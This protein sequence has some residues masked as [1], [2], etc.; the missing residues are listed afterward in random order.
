VED[1]EK[2]VIYVYQDLLNEYCKYYEP[3]I[4]PLPQDIIDQINNEENENSSN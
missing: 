1:G 2:T 4:E 3:I